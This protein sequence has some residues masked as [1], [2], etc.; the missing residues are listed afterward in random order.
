[1]TILRALALCAALAAP[2]AAFAQ[3]APERAQDAPAAATPQ[4]P[5]AAQP[6][7]GDGAISADSIPALRADRAPTPEDLAAALQLLSASHP[8]AGSSAAERDAEKLRAIE[9]IAT[10]ASEMVTAREA[11]TATLEVL[12]DELASLRAEARGMSGQAR[13]AMQPFT[14]Q[15]LTLGPPPDVGATEPHDVAVERAVIR[16]MLAGLDSR[17]RQADLT[18]TRLDGLVTDIDSLVRDRFAAQLATRGPTPLDIADWPGA[19]REIAVSVVDVGAEVVV[20][21]RDPIGQRERAERLPLLG[22]AIVLALVLGLWLRKRLI[23]ILM[24]A[25]PENAGRG[26]RVAVGAMI[27]A[28]RL[29]LPAASLGMIYF[30]LLFSGILG[31]KGETALGFAALG[32]ALLIAAQGIAWAYYSPSNPRFRLS[33][34]DDA[35]SLRAVWLSVGL[36]L[37]LC[38]D[39][40]LVRGGERLGFSA[41]TLSVLNLAVLSWGGVMMWGLAG[42]VRPA[43]EA[44]AAP[45][46]DA[47][48][49][50]AYDPTQD[51]EDPSSIGRRLMIIGALAMR[52][53]AVGA[54][55]LSLTGYYAAS[56]YV[57]FPTAMTLGLLAAGMLVFIMIRDGVD[58][59]LSGGLDADQPPR[60]ATPGGLR[61]LPILAGFLIILALIPQLALIWG[62]RQ[63]DLI[64]GW[65]LISGGFQMG[66]VRLSPVDFLTF[67]LVF[68]AVYAVSRLLQTVLRKSVLPNTRL[69]SGA[70]NAVASFAGYAGFAIAAISAVSAAGLDLSSLA[71][72]AGA[73]SV[74]IG[75]GLQNVVN[76]FVSGIIL[77][78]ERPIKVGDWIVVA[79]THGTVRK[80]S[81]RATEIETFDRSTLIVP[82]GDLISSSVMNMT[83]GNNVGRAII[84]VGVAYGT[85]VEKVRDILTEISTSHPAVLRYPAPQ[86]LFMEFGADSLN[87]EIRAILRDV[88]QVLSVKSHM[89]YKIESAFREAGIEIPFAQRDLHIRNPE[90]LGQALA[91]AMAPGRAQVIDD[92]APRSILRQP[93]DTDAAPGPSSA[94][95]GL[96]APDDGVGDDAR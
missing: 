42:L 91:A 94:Q 53:A 33:R 44:V 75:F 28:T 76:N 18:V 89:N 14:A 41:D 21:L 90:G 62:A 39:A 7:D 77:L 71:I 37:A 2:S 51:D 83:H 88:G 10:R 66:D 16:E 25:A 3:V 60:E 92:P 32:F 17:A 58:A 74:G 22:A 48:S 12:R 19:V 57:F 63:T 78:I 54:V 67:A 6:M 34:L 20:S 85:D 70:R 81:V 27:A 35:S 30:G 40:V 95:T 86:V 52:V 59:Y 56:R 73:L 50:A 29:L 26:R 1:M 13:S 43:R 93:A 31:E 68:I 82:N 79:N 15:M 11:S 46:I 4:D 96:E 69:D 72:V 23:A 36:G 45:S 5:V 87:F 61:L 38:L 55:L 24:K 8:E 65:S 9:V 49:I 80:I 47:D 64:N 84:P